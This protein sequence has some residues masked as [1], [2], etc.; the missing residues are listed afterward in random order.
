M[1]LRFYLVLLIFLLGLQAGSYASQPEDTKEI[2]MP[3]QTGSHLPHRVTV[4]VES[5]ETNATAK[6]KKTE[7]KKEQSKQNSVKP[8]PTPEPKRQKPAERSTPTPEPE[9]F[10]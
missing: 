10:R 1:N 5:G 3:P 8:S 9:R 6:K 2:L 7:S 4:P